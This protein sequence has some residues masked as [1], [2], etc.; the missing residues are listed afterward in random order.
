M[1]IS[2]QNCRR[3]SIVESQI[4]KIFACGALTS[5][6]PIEKVDFERRPI[7]QLPCHVSGLEDIQ[8]HKL[9]NKTGFEA[10]ER[11]LAD[12]QARKQA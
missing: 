8:R 11:G 5:K 3:K 10:L 6:V 2:L 7:E 4:L 9:E 1:S 12:Y